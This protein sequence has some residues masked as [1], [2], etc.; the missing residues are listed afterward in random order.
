MDEQSRDIRTILVATGLTSESL[1]ALDMAIGL[2]EKLGAE[3]HAVHVIEPMSKRAADAMP[4]LAE[5]HLAIAGEEFEKFAA[6]HELSGKATLHVKRGQPE[7]EILALRRELDADLLVIGRYGKGGLKRGSLG[8]VAH[9]TVRHCPV[10]ALVVEPTFRGSFTKIAVASD[11]DA[12]AH[13]ELLRGL[14]LGRMLGVESIM[15]I[16]AFELPMGYHTILTEEQARGKME[17]VCKSHADELIS[18]VRKEGDPRVEIVSVEGPATRAVPQM[19]KRLG[20]EVLVLSMHMHKSDSA[21]VLLGRTTERIL[22]AV[23]CSVW[24]E[25]TPELSQGWWAAVKRLFD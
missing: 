13:V 11:L 23:D 20:V 17:G 22:N 16:K 5:K 14:W 25:T 3:L 7:H 24:A 8:S 1:G 18:R 15:L 21:G 9:S 4:G 10:S 19:C 6:S 12:D 2:G